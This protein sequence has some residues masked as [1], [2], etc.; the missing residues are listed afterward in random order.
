MS[1]EKF[2]F[3]QYFLDSKSFL[4]LFNKSFILT[5]A[6]TAW[7]SQIGYAQKDLPIS[8]KSII[9][10][11]DFENFTRWCS[12]SELNTKDKLHGIKMISADGKLLDYTVNVKLI[13]GIFHIILRKTN[14]SSQRKELLR[15]LGES[16]KIGS[17]SY[18]VSNNKVFWSEALYDIYDIDPSE[19]PS[20]Q[21]F[22]SRVHK[23]D[24]A[25]LQLCVDRLYENNE[26]YKVTFKFL[27]SKGRTRFIKS[28][29][30]PH[31][32]QGKVISVSGYAQDVSEEAYQKIKLEKDHELIQLA[33]RGI[34]SGIFDHN[35]VNG[36]IEYGPMFRE[37]IGLPRKLKEKDFRKLIHPDDAEGA[38]QRH[39]EGIQ[40]SGNNYFNH[41][42]LK[43]KQNIYRHFEVYGWR[44]KDAKGNP[45]RMVGN[46]IDADDKVKSRQKLLELNRQLAAMVNNG[47]VSMILLDMEGHAIMLDEPSR[48]EMHEEFGTDPLEEGA[49][50][51]DLIPTSEHE[52]FSQEYEKAK[53]GMQSRRELLHIYED[54]SEKWFDFYVSPVFDDHDE[55]QNVLLKYIDITDLKRNE[56]K[57]QTAKERAEELSS[58]KTNFLANMS[59]EIRTP[60]N[61]ILSV[62]EL[63]PMT[64]ENE[65]IRQLVSMQKESGERLL[66]TLTGILNLSLLEAEKSNLKLTHEYLSDLVELAFNSFEHLAKKKGLSYVFENKVSGKLKISVDREMTVAS[67]KN[68][69][70]N[71]IKFTDQG[72]IKVEVRQEKNM[73]ACSVTD[74]G[75]GISDKDLDQIFN[76]FR[77]GSE[78]LSRNFEGTGIGLSLTKKYLDLLGAEIQVESTHKKGSNFTIKIP[79]KE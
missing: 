40:A 41:Y 49:L 67:L 3:Q 59:H 48:K 71:A 43:N 28:I 65:E 22:M 53:N 23:D 37:I 60:L 42:R 68:L 14:S 44:Q 62:A 8:L 10:D 5:E 38:Y 35:L 75:I 54:G 27:D 66:E 1:I 47:I 15:F 78:G 30:K 12:N 51:I 39:K 36:D 17:F 45:L 9:P 31:V 58:M 57:A 18:D 26:G 56:R 21:L 77:Q 32:H 19:E 76:S 52:Q 6:S 34:K 13:D 46:L 29:A 50:F 33:I 55:V 24:K 25:L 73:A 63:I 4:G 72:G 7:L 69:I 64:T 16:A 11:I 61:G 79:L 70:H 74:T 2:N 20:A